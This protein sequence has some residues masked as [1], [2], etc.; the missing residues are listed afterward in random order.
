[1]SSNDFSGQAASAAPEPSNAEES[2]MTRWQKFRLVVK[3]VELRLR[4]IALMAATGLVFAYWDTLWNYY[5]KWT[6]PVGEHVAAASDI[7]Y[8]CPMHPSVVRE[9]PGNCPICGM[10]LSKRKKGQ[11]EELPEGVTARVHLAPFRVA[12]AGIRTAEITYEPLVETVTTVGFVAFDERRLSH[13]SS[14]TKGLARVEKLFVNFTGTFV[15][16]GQPLA[17]LYSPELYQATRELLL[18]QGADSE[19]ANAQNTLP[20]SLLG[21]RGNLVDLAREKLAL[22]GITPGQI[23]EILAKGKADYRLSILA[24][25]SGY[26]V[27]K[28]I[29]EGHYVSE[30]EAMF[31][32][33]DLSHVW[34]QAK[35]FEDQVDRIRLG[36]Q[37][38]AAGESFPGEVFKG[39]VAFIDPILDPTTR[40]VN[41]R[42]DLPNPEGRLR[43]GMYVT[44]TLKTP[45]ADTP[46]FRTRLAAT[47]PSGA[48]FRHASMT[49]E[50]QKTCPV[51]EAKLG[52]MGDPIAVEVAGRKVWVCCPGCPPKLETDSAKYL[53]KLTPQA[54][55]A[56]AVLSVP[57]SA[58]IDTGDRKVVYV[59]TQPGVFEGRAVVLGSRIG[60]RYPVLQGLAP[61]ERV[62]AAGAFLIDAES[63][64]NPAFSGTK[65]LRDSA[66]AAH[67]HPK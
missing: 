8:Y 54:S 26:V 35:I 9:A 62:A 64:L 19:R 22:W 15:E 48:Q 65:S 60:D 30:G 63:R 34:V 31:E 43:P 56:D 24:P 53:A 16:R 51:T 10:P 41:V 52:S 32:I 5:D 44:V 50:A 11:K 36:E 66:I 33:A 3:V 28:Y 55:P 49:V 6:R 12:Q 39:N 20:Q 23:D 1:M 38:E 45:V 61:G 29:V 17:E 18:A 47:H 14:K 2:P 7:E 57:E 58:V 4:F 27:R 46:A 67:E 42:Y 40:T 37:V 21:N 25:I 13:I 59:E